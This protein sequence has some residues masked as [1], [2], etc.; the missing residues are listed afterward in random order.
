M[1]IFVV[2]FFFKAVYLQYYIEWA[3]TL[4]YG[5]PSGLF[6]NFLLHL[7]IWTDH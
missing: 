3:L 6:P 2:F 1:S 7:L 5:I 4:N